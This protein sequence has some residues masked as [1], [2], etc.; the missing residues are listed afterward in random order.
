MTAASTKLLDAGELPT[1][2]TPDE[3]AELIR[4]TAGALAQDRYLGRGVTAFHDAT[5]SAWRPLG[6]R[7]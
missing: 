4:T 5:S 3:L 1:F 2:L 7:A 6:L